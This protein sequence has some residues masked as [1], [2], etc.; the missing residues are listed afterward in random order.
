MQQCK[1]I[2]CREPSESF[3][4]YCYHHCQMFEVEEASSGRSSDSNKDVSSGGDNDYWVAP[5]THP[6]RLVP[7][8]AECEDIIE[9]FQMSFQEGEAFKAL[10]RKGQARLGNGKPGDTPLRNAQKVAHYGARMTAMEERN[11]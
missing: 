5:I 9:Y 7:Y 6:K 8:V 4:D 3:Q 1:M 11:T 10:W 2:G